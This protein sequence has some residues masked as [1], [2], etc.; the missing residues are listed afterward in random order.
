M[1]DFD[2]DTPQIRD[3]KLIQ[4]L[5]DKVPDEKALQATAKEKVSHRQLAIR[6]GAVVEA[7]SQAVDLVAFNAKAAIKFTY[8]FTCITHFDS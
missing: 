6:N 5:I 3:S 7:N 2:R 4:S 1:S 8:N